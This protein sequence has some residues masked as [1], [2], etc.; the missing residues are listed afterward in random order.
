MPKSPHGCDF[1]RVK[2][3]YLDEQAKYLRQTIL[4]SRFDTPETRSLFHKYCFNLEGKVR[5]EKNDYPGVLSY[6]K[7]GVKQVFERIDGDSRKGLG[8]DAA[9][10]EV[11]QRLEYFVKKVST[12]CLRYRTLC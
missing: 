11:D 5:L 4:L 1:S 7:P 10:E 2:N 8:G 3:W 6:I 12:S 9:V